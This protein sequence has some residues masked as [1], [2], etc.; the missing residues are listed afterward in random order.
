V[1]A[2]TRNKQ[3][4]PLFDEESDRIFRYQKQNGRGIGRG[5]GQG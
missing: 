1:L 2:L 5:S 3:R 4:L